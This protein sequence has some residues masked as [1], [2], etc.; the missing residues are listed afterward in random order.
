MWV[1]KSTDKLLMSSFPWISFRLILMLIWQSKVPSHPS[2]FCIS[3]CISH[4]L[5]LKTRTTVPSVDTYLTGCIIG[6]LSVLNH[7]SLDFEICQLGEQRKHGVGFEL[8]FIF[9]SVPL[10]SDFE[11]QNNV[12]GKCCP[13][14]SI[15]IRRGP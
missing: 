2:I 4:V 5:Y 6:V 11:A 9:I 14:K 12:I 13:A 3:Y 7:L 15:E 1:S 10:K 8:R